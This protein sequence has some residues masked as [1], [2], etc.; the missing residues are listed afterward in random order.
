MSRSEKKRKRRVRLAVGVLLGGAFGCLV[1]SVVLAPLQRAMLFPGTGLRAP[2]TFT[3]RSAERWTRSIAEGEIEAFFLPATRTA[4]L[5]SDDAARPV[6]IF[7]HGNGELVDH[8]PPELQPYRDLGIHVLLP[9][10]R[11]YGRSAGSPSE[12]GIAE[13]FE[14]FYDRLV[15]RADVDPARVIFHGRSLGGGAVGALATAREPAALILQSTFAS[16]PELAKR[17]FVPEFLVADRFDTC[18]WLRGYDRPVL[19]FHGTQDELIPFRHAELLEEA[20]PHGTLVRY[21]AGHNNLPPPGSDYWERIEAFLR[22]A[23]LL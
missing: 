7:A 3:D 22:T 12:E 4:E 8:W 13:D 9:E 6:V 23:N 2:A 5:G 17:W 19:L 14:F 11:G 21:R 20:A 16:L 1:F 15:A 18:A 10:Y